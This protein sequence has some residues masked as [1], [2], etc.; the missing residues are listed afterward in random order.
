[1]MLSLAMITNLNRHINVYKNNVS[2]WEAHV[3]N[4]IGLLNYTLYFKKEVVKLKVVYRHNRN[5]SLSL[6]AHYATAF[7]TKITTYLL[8]FYI[9]Q[10]H[11]SHYSK[12][13]AL[14]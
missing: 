4:N 2:E 12:Q 6:N 9:L 11:L 7:A 5:R 8:V 14:S 3:N 1:M 13:R 10:L